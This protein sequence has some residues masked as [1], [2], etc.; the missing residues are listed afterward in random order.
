MDLMI[1]GTVNQLN[2]SKQNQLGL[3]ENFDE[4]WSNLS[5]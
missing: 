4:F 3:I 1:F 2:L 5:K